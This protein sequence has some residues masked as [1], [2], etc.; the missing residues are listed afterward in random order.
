M[1]PPMSV[2]FPICETP[3]RSLA[4]PSELKVSI[5]SIYRV[6]K[7][8]R[9]GRKS[10]KVDQSRDDAGGSAGTSCGWLIE[11]NIYHWMWG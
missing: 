8:K 2:R 3:S 7:S 1:T 4:D 10:W 11:G 9:E 5:K 6:V